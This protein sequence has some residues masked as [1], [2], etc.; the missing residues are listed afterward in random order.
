MQLDDSKLLP[1]FIAAHNRLPITVQVV[2]RPRHYC[3]PLSSALQATRVLS[4]Y[5]GGRQ[6]WSGQNSPLLPHQLAA[7]R[8]VMSEDEM[9]GPR[10]RKL[11]GRGVRKVGCCYFS[12]SLPPDRIFWALEFFLEKLGKRCAVHLE[13]SRN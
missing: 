9:A 8:V 3:S 2:R 6:R 13:R 1:T 12:G 10:I 11:L 4:D 5:Y 7:L